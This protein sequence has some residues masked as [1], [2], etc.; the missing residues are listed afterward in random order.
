MSVSQADSSDFSMHQF[1]TEDD[2]REG[3]STNDDDSGEAEMAKSKALEAEDHFNSED[4]PD[5]S[6]TFLQMGSKTIR[7]TAADVT[8]SRQ[9]P[10]TTDDYEYGDREMAVSQADSS[11]FSMHQF[12]AA[13]DGREGTSTNDDDSGEAEMAK[14]KAL[15]ADDHFNSEDTPDTSD[16]FLQTGSKTIKVKAAD[17]A[18]SRQ[19]PGTTDDYEYGDREMAV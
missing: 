14:S 16:S 13:D 5:T 9:D 10:G 1:L 19:D 2:G 8:K 18:K 15:E 7:V 3:T 11:D 17:A 12:L 6:D 4:T